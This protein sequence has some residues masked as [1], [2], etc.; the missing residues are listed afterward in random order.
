[1]NSDS[2]V[3]G[4][5]IDRYDDGKHTYSRSVSGNFTL[6]TA[7]AAAEANLREIGDGVI[8]ASWIEQAIAKDG[9]AVRRLGVVRWEFSVT[10]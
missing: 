1:M 10:T 2:P 5:T 7:C 6:A 8:A 3:K 9:S 4:M